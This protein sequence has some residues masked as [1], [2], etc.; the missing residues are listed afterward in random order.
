MATQ[1]VYSY[2]VDPR[3]LL[4][5]GYSDAGTEY[6]DVESFVKTDKNV[7]VKFSYAW[8]R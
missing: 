5:V 2:K 3:T 4:F 6:D 1:L 7:F 8:R